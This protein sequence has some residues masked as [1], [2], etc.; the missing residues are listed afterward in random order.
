MT[1]NESLELYRE[2]YQANLDRFLGFC[3]DISFD[4]QGFRVTSKGIDD[5][6]VLTII[7]PDNT[8]RKVNVLQY[9]G[10]LRYAGQRVKELEGGRG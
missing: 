1:V 2:Q 7:R 4:M 5:N 8:R 9:L 6:M 10:M 3:D